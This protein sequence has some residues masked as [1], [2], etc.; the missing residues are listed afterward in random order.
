MRLHNAFAETI[1]QKYILIKSGFPVDLDEL[2]NFLMEWIKTHIENEDRKYADHF[3][4]KGHRINTDF[5]SAKDKGESESIKSRVI[6]LWDQ[7]K[8]ALN[9]KE[10]DNQHKELVYILMQ[11]SD[12]KKTGVSPNRDLIQLPILIKKLF[13]YSK[14]HFESEESLMR[15]I[16]YPDLQKHI[17][18]HLEF[19]DAVKNFAFKFKARET[20]LTDEVL[21][22]LKDWTINHILDED[23]KIKTYL[24]SDTNKN[25]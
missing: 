13:Y 12:L 19:I 7:R 3:T 16:E 25:G 14:F 18:I 17:K 1:K 23:A 8:L 2:L 9:I 21:L 5:V 6:N 24:D 11:V 4:K 15:E 20:N 10:I 22:F